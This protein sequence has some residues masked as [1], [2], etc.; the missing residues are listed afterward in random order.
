MKGFTF[1][2]LIIVSLLIIITVACKNE[3]ETDAPIFTKG[4]VVDIDGN[5]YQTIKIGTQEWMAENL[6]V[7]HY[8]NSADIPNVKDYSAWYNLSTDAYC[9]YENDTTNI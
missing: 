3:D 7:K 1:N 2:N 8:R 4:K 5:V 6:K 9:C